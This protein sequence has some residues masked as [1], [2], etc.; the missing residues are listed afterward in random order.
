MFDIA[1]STTT[2]KPMPYLRP[3]ARAAS[4]RRLSSASRPSPTAISTARA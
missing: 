2:A 3:A 4:R 1:G